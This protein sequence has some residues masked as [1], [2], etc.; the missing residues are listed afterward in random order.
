M[1]DDEGSKWA[2]VIGVF[3]TWVKSLT[4]PRS[5]AQTLIIN[6]FLPRL[7]AYASWSS[8][9]LFF[10]QS[11]SL[12]ANTTTNRTAAKQSVCRFQPRIRSGVQTSRCNLP[13]RH[14][15]SSHCYGTVVRLTS[16][17]SITS[18]VPL[19][20]IPSTRCRLLTTFFAVW[21]WC[22]GSSAE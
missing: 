8:V 12:A 22:F 9:R 7:H 4:Y 15:S 1:S 2:D 13:R 11:L 21:N 20:S 17:A 19:A 14:T 6:L 10:R 16:V 5:A 3:L 18:F